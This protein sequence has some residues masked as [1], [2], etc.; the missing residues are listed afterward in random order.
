MNPFYWCVIGLLIGSISANIRRDFGLGWAI[1][2][3][4]VCSIPVAYFTPPLF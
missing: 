1:G 2:F 3:L 4:T